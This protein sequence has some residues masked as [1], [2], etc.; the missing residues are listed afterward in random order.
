M[1]LINLHNLL[2]LEINKINLIFITR[3]KILTKVFQ[4]LATNIIKKE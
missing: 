1:K 2:I 3:R 4:I